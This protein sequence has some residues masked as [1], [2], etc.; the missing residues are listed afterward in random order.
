[1]HSAVNAVLLACLF[2]S[3]FAA[4]VG[5]PTDHLV[6]LTKR[7]IV[8]GLTKGIPV[9]GY[10]RGVLDSLPVAGSIGDLTNTLPLAGDPLAGAHKRGLLD[11]LPVASSVGDLTNTLP[12][13][14]DPLAG[15]HKRGLLDS[16]PAVG[17]ADDLTKG[18][19]L[20]GDKSKRDLDIPVVGRIG[21]IGGNDD[22][23]KRSW[24][25]LTLLGKDDEAAKSPPPPTPEGE[26]KTY[27]ELPTPANFD[28]TL[29]PVDDFANGP[30]LENLTNKLSLLGRAPRDHDEDDEVDVDALN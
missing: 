3:S 28:Q 13:A 16:L 2:G 15:A 19:P 10:K 22:H 25:L 29:K 8:N 1:M 20:A 5:N 30:A 17:S 27:P 7:D 24:D 9:L 26:V 4:P 12:L 18:L 6:A 11:S 14:G 21:R 23:I